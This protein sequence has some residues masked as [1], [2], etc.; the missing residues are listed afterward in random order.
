MV[1][2][3]DSVVARE[4][5][6]DIDGSIKQQSPSAIATNPMGIDTKRR[7]EIPYSKPSSLERDIA[8]VWRQYHQSHFRDEIAG[9]CSGVEQCER[10]L[11]RQPDKQPIT[12]KD[13]DT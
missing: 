11:L 8:N 13:T 5:A 1:D 10:D 4:A 9:L 3:E 2:G 12:R 7:I 6:G